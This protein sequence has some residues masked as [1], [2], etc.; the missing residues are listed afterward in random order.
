MTQGYDP[1]YSVTLQAVLKDVMSGIAAPHVILRDHDLPQRSG[2]D[3]DI[4]IDEQD[5]KQIIQVCLGC[6]ETHNVFALTH[7]NRV[8]FLDISH[9]GTGRKWAMLDLQ[10]IY[11]YANQS[12]DV[13]ALLAMADAARK[14]LFTEVQAA[15]KGN[16]DLQ[17]KYG[18]QP[19]VEKLESSLSTVERLKRSMLERC[20]FIHKNRPL[21]VV[22][23][24]PDG[25][26]KTTL[27]TNMLK[28]FDGLPFLI[29]HFHHTGLAKGEAAQK[30][31][32]SDESQ[33][34]LARRLRR[35]FTPHVI[36]TLY[37]AVTGELNYAMRLNKEVVQNFYQGRFIFS[38]RYIYDRTVKMQMSPDKLRISKFLTWINAKLMRPPTIMIVPQDTPDAIYKRNKS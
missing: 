19:Y 6:A 5:L 20:F 10:S 31:V 11:K 22:I 32:T 21:F 12:C 34:S 30:P 2:F 18:I 25:V 26:G 24:G 27:L 16:K 23:S 28:V 8:A 1:L 29:K 3:I 14:T 15:R 35:R 38:D 17:D 36:K 13:H 7:Q 33:M 37:G 9:G 4:L